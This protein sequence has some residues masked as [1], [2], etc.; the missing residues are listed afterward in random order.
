MTAA[1]QSQAMN[2]ITVNIVSV[3]IVASARPI[4][5]FVTQHYAL[6]A[7]LNARIANNRYVGVAQLHAPNAKK[8]LVKTVLLKKEYANNV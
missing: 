3:S 8:L 2:A 5:R 4:V 6:D 7:A 1:I